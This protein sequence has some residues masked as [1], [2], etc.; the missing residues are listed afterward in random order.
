MVRM[1]AIR[2][3][4]GAGL[5]VLALSGC[6][7]MKGWFAS[8][9]AEAKKAAE[10]AELVDFQA[11]ANPAKVWSAKLGEGEGKIGAR[12]HPAVADGRVF[13]A[14]TDG[15]V[16]ALDLHT[17]KEAW[18]FK[19][20]K[21]EGLRLSGG[22]GVGEGLVVVGS[23]GGDVI[24]LDAANGGERWR[25]KVSC[26]VIAAPLVAQGHV[27]VRSND[28]RIS[29]FDAANG[30]RSWF[31]EHELPSLTVRGNAPLAYGP[32]V[33]FSGNDDGSLTALGMQ[34]GRQLWQQA[35]GLQ[36]GRSELDR[37]ADVDSGPLIDGVL[38]FASSFKN[39]TIAID[40]PSGR[41]M[42]Q[43]DHGG[44]G[45]MAVSPYGLLVSSPAGSVYL[46]DKNSGAALWSQPAL[47]RRSITGPAVHGDYAVVGDLD[48]Y[49]HWMRLSDG[50]MAARARA[51]RKPIK[52]QPVVA[53][54]ILLVQTI[55][56]ELTA[57][58][59]D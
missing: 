51:G 33:L 43:S 30:E 42:W 15:G 46:L 11:S 5:L 10:P 44:I 20:G 29:A 18:R 7:T 12:Q 49:L 23:L 3:A 58:R 19:A 36:E 40:G 13:A 17:G 47:A 48:G 54:G 2:A 16:V 45:G 4:A 35:V 9:D 21:K 14:A 8:K 31:T 50:E 55:D 52:G 32:G 53:D 26:A 41:P 1:H 34:D 59:L 39:R 25:A 28:G 56:G 38:L 6:S 22:P 57:F 24:A 37:M 27:F